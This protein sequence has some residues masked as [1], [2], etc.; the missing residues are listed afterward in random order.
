VTFQHCLEPK[1][2]DKKS[3]ESKTEQI[4]SDEEGDP[5]N[6][7]CPIRFDVFLMCLWCV[8]DVF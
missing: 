1:E 7:C 3:D 8:S 2:K 5:S 6:Y 4:D